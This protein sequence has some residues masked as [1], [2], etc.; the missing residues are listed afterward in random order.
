VK[1]KVSTLFGWS[2]ENL[3]AGGDMVMPYGWMKTTCEACGWSCVTHQ[4][5]DVLMPPGRCGKCGGGKL[6][7]ER[8][9]VGDVVN[10]VKVWRG[11][12]RRY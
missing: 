3:E 6:R 12:S 5:S 1:T 11:L 2:F 10:P 8:A 7:H 4:P 9:G